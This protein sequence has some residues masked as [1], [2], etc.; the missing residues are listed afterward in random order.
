[1]TFYTLRALKF[2]RYPVLLV[3]IGLPVY[4]ALPS[5]AEFIKYEDRIFYTTL[6]LF[7]A[8]CGALIVH[9]AFWEKFFAV[10]TLTEDEIRW[11]CPFRR[12]KVISVHECKE[13]GAYLENASSGIPCEQI[14]FSIFPSP[15]KKDTHGT[16]KVSKGIIKFWYTPELCNYLL[17]N[18][19]NN[20]ENL[21][22]YQQQR[23][24]KY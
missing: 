12:T 19:S 2:Y 20:I 23:N 16:I 21:I 10:L 7:L 6:C 14:Y 18:H 5:S 9:I 1:M 4:L 3:F 13:I 15:Q 11:S 24:K 17:E 22:V 8:V